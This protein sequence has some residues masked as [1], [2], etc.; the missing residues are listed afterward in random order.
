MALTKTA[1]ERIANN[2]PVTGGSASMVAT[3]HFWPGL[4]GQLSAL[5]KNGV[6]ETGLS[7]GRTVFSL[8][9]SSHLDS[10]LAAHYRPLVVDALR[11][12][13][14]LQDQRDLNRFLTEIEREELD[15]IL[16]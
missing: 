15:A 3:R 1:H 10:P 16:K 4:D 7:D 6:I 2:Q 14:R 8:K 13:G 11:W 12:S 5:V 9:D